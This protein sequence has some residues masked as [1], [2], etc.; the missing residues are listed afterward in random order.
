MKKTSSETLEARSAAW[1]RGFTLVELLVVIG[2][3]AL[4]IS[5]LLPSL[6]RARRQAAQVQCS[7]NM[8]QIGLSI[9]QYAN[10]NKGKLMAAQIL[11][12]GT[13]ATPPNSLYSDGFG[14]SNE[15]VQ[16]G[17]IKAP[18]VYRSI[19]GGRFVRDFSGASAF[20]CPEGIASEDAGGS[21]TAIVGPPTAPANNSFY[22]VRTKGQGSTEPY[23]LTRDDGQTPYATASWY[24]LNARTESSALNDT[25]SSNPSRVCPFV[26]F[27]SAA[28]DTHIL[29]PGFSRRI[30]QIRKASQ[31]IMVVEAADANWV[32]ITNGTTD[33]KGR[34]TFIGRIGARHGKKTADGLNASTNVCFFDGHVETKDSALFYYTNPDNWYGENGM[35]LYVNKQK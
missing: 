18:N 27:T 20:R 11:N 30:S 23:T 19:G 7:S 31:M 13:R 25:T 21:S 26:G 5:I 15:L 12:N 14:W 22:F 4:L 9:I 17:Y 2:I 32:N 3:I 16:K 29:S 28:T 10:D 8:R 24:Q 6:N 35:I 1:R 33:P 34:P